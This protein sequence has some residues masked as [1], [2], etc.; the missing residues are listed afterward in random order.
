MSQPMGT[1]H[2]SDHERLL[3]KQIDLVEER[4]MDIVEE[5]QD[6]SLEVRLDKLQE[7]QRA[8]AGCPA[9]I[10]KIFDDVIN[11]IRSKITEAKNAKRMAER[12]SRVTAR[13]EE[14]VS[15]VKR[16]TETSGGVLRDG[17][18]VPQPEPPAS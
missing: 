3:S 5:T 4:I 6:K 18:V 10:E 13:S 15:L 12:A 16:V 8:H 9:I 2:E 11:P 17:D 14:K 1:M 7:L